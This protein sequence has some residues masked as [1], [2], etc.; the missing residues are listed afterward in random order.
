MVNSKD[1]ISSK[2]NDDSSAVVPISL[3]DEKKETSQ[4][5]LSSIKNVTQPT[6]MQLTRFRVVQ[7]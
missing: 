3:A 1:A 5:P 7:K 4:S 2:R 6:P